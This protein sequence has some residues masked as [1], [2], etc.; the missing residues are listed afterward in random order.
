MDIV[1]QST[2][3]IAFDPNTQKTI[4]LAGRN[5]YKS[6]DR[7]KKGSDIDL[8]KRLLRMGHESV[9]EHGSITVR[10]ITDRGVTHELV[11]HRLAAY[12]QESTRYCNYGKQDIEFILPVWMD[13]MYLGHYNWNIV[14]PIIGPEKLFLS[15]CLWSEDAYKNLLNEGWTAQYARQVLNNALK[16]DIVM[17]ANI[18]EW[19]HIFNLRCDKAAH[20]QIRNLMLTLLDEMCILFPVLFEDI[21]QKHKRK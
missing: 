9:I 16:T 11:R 20:P 4:E 17:T 3:I 1:K 18:R 2:E 10:F 6:E 14:N 8:I 7:I 19:R 13:E 5:C 12:S 15:A 21:K